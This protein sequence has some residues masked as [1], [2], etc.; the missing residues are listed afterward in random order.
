MSCFSFVS[1][2]FWVPLA[3]GAFGRSWLKGLVRSFCPHNFQSGRSPFKY[4]LNP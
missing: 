1:V 3:A 2:S 4:C